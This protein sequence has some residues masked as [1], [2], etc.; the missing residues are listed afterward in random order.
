MGTLE[1]EWHLLGVGRDGSHRTTSSDE[2]RRNTGVQQVMS[3]CVGRDSHLGTLSDVQILT[4]RDSITVTSVD[5]VECF[6][7]TG[8]RQVCLFVFLEI[9]EKL[10]KE[11]HFL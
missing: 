6:Q 11:S 8:R 5:K 4:L 2:Q 10:I 1:N 7:S 3:T 9:L